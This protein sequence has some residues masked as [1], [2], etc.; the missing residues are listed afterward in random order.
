M[1]VA[2]DIKSLKGRLDR[3]FWDNGS[4]EAVRL[5]TVLRKDFAGFP[6]MGVIGGLVRDFARAGRSAF[7]S[8][9]DLVIAA[10]PADVDRLASRLGARRN[11][12]GGYGYRA[13][14]WNVDFWALESTWAAAQGYVAVHELADVTRCVFFDW[15]AVVYDLGTRRV[16]CDRS[17]LDRIRHGRMEISL[18]ENP[19][20][21]GNLLRATRRIIRWK[22]EPGPA[23]RRFID[24][25]LTEDALDAM[26][27]SEHRKYADRVLDGYPDVAALRHALLHHPRQAKEDP[28]M[29]LGL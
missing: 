26:R 5:R 19:G 28:Q 17:Y 23:L 18:L 25:H 21:M 24:E 22:L 13:E 8:D 12:F 4:T 6:Q 11:R 1:P 9:I 7:K 20:L 2:P 3:F 10:S 16:L 29:G 14:P 15:D 27:A